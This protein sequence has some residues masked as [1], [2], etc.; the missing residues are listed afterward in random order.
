MEPRITTI[1]L[2][3]SDLTKSIRFYRDGLGFPAKI[4]EGAPIAFFT[5]HGT[6]LALYPLGRLGDYVGQPAA[7][8]GSPFGGIT[9]GHNVRTREEV[10][11][12]LALAETAGGKILKPAQKVFWGGVSG[13]FS[14]PDGHLWEVAWAPMFSFDETGALIF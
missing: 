14:D 3:V 6:R 2:G 10:D 4:E 8:P 5:T 13:I 12:V 1:T 9:L 11:E 7:K